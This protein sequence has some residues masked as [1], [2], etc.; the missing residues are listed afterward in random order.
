MD[1]QRDVMHYDLLIIGAGP[2][3]LAAAIRFRQLAEKAGRELS[4]C[5]LEK[6]AQVGAQVLSGAVIDPKG[7]DELLPEWRQMD[8]P[9]NTAVTR[10]QLSWLTPSRK[11]PLPT[12][13]LP[14]L[15]HNDGC[16][17]GSLG[18]LC[19][20]L[21]TQAEALGV[22]IYPGFA[23]VAPLLDEDGALT[24]V[25]TGDMGVD[26]AGQPKAEYAPGIEIRAPYTLVAEGAR[27]SLTGQLETLFGLR[28]GNRFQKYG[29]GLKEVW[30]VQA[31]K[32]VPG[33]I[34]HT[35]G[36]PLN[37]RT[38]GGS[39]LY[40]Y[41][42]N[43][44]AIGFVVHLDYDNPHLSPYQ[45]FQRYKQ[46]PQ[47]RPVLEGGRRIAYGARAINEGGLQSLPDLVFP[48]GALIGCS[49]G[50]VNL[51]RIKGSHNAMKSGML[52]AEAAFA[53]LELP[54]DAPKRRLETYPVSLRASWAWQDL[55]AVRNVK[56]RLARYGTVL[57]S[58]ISGIEMWLSRFGV[59]LPWTL[60]HSRPDHAALRPAAEAPVI[61]YPKP[62][63][64]VSFDRLSS[65]ALSNIAHDHDQPNHLQLKDAA[66]PTTLNLPVYDA[67]EQRYCPAGVYEIVESE[68]A[69]ALQI[70]SQNCIHCKTCDIKDPTQ[71]IRWVTPEGG[72]GPIYNNM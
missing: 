39:F 72:S 66:V 53:A 55:D 64:V 69:P 60:Q 24:G 36:W 3:G 18:E 13:L 44:V 50:F 7:L 5:V 32:H 40:H 43:L 42:D 59:R 30:Q 10:E 17:T 70:N 51:P 16:Y 2:A 38:G 56:P 35:L 63:N 58:L 41:G 45:E 22:E 15:M 31:D 11:I 26:A 49:A 61:A 46:H 33:L 8:A 65:L 25:L 4:V 57:G 21:A 67:P 52:A 28:D 54:A 9:L 6:G 48:G 19:Q 27:G 68:G 34:E 62:D 23:A 1:I 71:N 14:P 47:V 37:D 29:L 20:W 12:G